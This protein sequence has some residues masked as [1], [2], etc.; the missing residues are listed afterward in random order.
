MR[1]PTKVDG[2][3]LINSMS[4]GESMISA[5]FIQKT[6]KVDL[7]VRVNHAYPHQNGHQKTLEDSRGHH[8]MAESEGLLGVEHTRVPVHS[9]I[10]VPLISTSN[11]IEIPTNQSW[12]HIR[13]TEI[14]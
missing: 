11:Q 1:S 12:F 9:I 5:G 14:G 3:K 10:T 6:I 8:A 7:D 4:F 13:G 2:F